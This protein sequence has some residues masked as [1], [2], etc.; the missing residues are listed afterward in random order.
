MPHLAS[1]LLA[2][3]GYDLILVARRRLNSPA[4]PPLQK[5]K[6]SEI[7]TTRYVAPK[8]KALRCDS[9]IAHE[10]ASRLAKSRSVR[11]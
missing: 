5:H 11:T 9:A 1:D 4:R 2:G 10:R 6:R 7:V 3:C 8:A